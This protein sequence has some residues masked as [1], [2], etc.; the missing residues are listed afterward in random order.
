MERAPWI[1]ALRLV[2][3]CAVLCFHVFYLTPVAEM[4]ASVQRIASHGYLGVEVFFIISGYVI[5]LSAAGRTHWAFVRA[6][7][8][9][10]WPA[11]LIAAVLCQGVRAVRGDPLSAPHFLANLTMVPHFFRAPY[12]DSVY[13]TLMIE[14]IFYGYIALL[15]GAGFTRRLR[16]FATAW[17]AL[18][19]ANLFVT[20]P[21]TPF[22][23]LQYAPF[24]VTGI[25]I[26][27][28]RTHNL[29]FDRML[30]LVATGT[31]M[32]AAARQAAWIGA[33]LEIQP[34][35]AI[36]AAVV[37]V[38]A[39]AVAWASTAKSRLAPLMLVA[40]GIS[41][42][43][44]LLHNE[45]GLALQHWLGL[46]AS[47]GVVFVL[48]YLVWRMERIVRAQF[49]RSRDRQRVKAGSRY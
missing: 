7:V 47:I 48:S 11:F 43:L 41:Y 13:W 22:L 25:A 15:L 8:L 40:G 42:P 37:G 38:S 14:I 24:F 4:P 19:I 12:L 17:L 23:A 21:D 46:P 16:L 36:V 10:L 34:Q 32:A 18:A 49:S 45:V 33:G 5:S 39:L 26:H 9:R 27:L 35:P 20:L 2:A 31:A 6:R 3:A 29:P 30:G 44:Y 28:I 1:D